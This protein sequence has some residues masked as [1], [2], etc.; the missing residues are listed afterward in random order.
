MSDLP[1]T[2]RE[3][4]LAA[5][6][7]L[8][9]AASLLVI[10]QFFP[11]DFNPSQPGWTYWSLS[12]K[13]LIDAFDPAGTTVITPSPFFFLA[14]FICDTAFAI[15]ALAAPWMIGF[16]HR[17]NP[18][19]W[20]IRVILVGGCGYLAWSCISYAPPQFGRS[21]FLSVLAF[22]METLGFFLI[23]P[24]SIKVP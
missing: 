7:V 23:P 22:A 2:V 13:L 19:L 17:A 15:L 16:L 14:V 5:R 6:V 8:I 18:L 10:S 4:I 9:I 11:L 21:A 3:R 24:R 1:D 20:T 12:F